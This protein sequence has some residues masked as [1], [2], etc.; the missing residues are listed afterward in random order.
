[1]GVVL[2]DFTHTLAAEGPKIRLMLPLLRAKLGRWRIDGKGHW[3]CLSFA[4]PIPSD[5]TPGL[6]ILIY[7]IGGSY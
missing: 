5:S 7:K 3:L 6:S 2:G 1:M 4:V